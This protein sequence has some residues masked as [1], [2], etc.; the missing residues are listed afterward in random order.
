MPKIL[1]DLFVEAVAS[2]D[3]KSAK[4]TMTAVIVTILAGGSLVL[5]QLEI[6]L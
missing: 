1:K 4:K 5:H 3:I 6:G 2:G